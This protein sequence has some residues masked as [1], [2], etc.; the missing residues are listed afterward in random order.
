[1]AYFGC[2]L[3][4]SKLF[5]ETSLSCNCI[6]RSLDMKRKA[7]TSDSLFQRKTLAKS[8][9]SKNDKPDKLPWDRVL[10]VANMV[11]NLLR[12]LLELDH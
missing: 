11:L 2:A 12:I 1:V 10:I 9:R 8:R 4:I 7:T 3:S 6:E 5:Q